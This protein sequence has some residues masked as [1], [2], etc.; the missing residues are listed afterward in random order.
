MA[1]RW[2]GLRVLVY[3]SFLFLVGACWCLLDSPR[4]LTFSRLPARR[5]HKIPAR[6]HGFCSMCGFYS[7]V[8]SSTYESTLGST[9]EESQPRVGPACKNPQQAAS[10]HRASRRLPVFPLLYAPKSAFFQGHDLRIIPCIRMNVKPT[11]VRVLR[12]SGN[13]S[14]L[15]IYIRIR[16]YAHFFCDNHARQL[17]GGLFDSMF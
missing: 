7:F 3:C 1:T 8:C 5:V 16:T 15:R 6:V 9:P 12:T 14:D 17:A 2:W 11:N 13:V 4:Y 10:S